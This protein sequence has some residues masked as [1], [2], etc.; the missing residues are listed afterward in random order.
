MA[1]QP[2]RRRKSLRHWSLLRHVAD[3]RANVYRRCDGH[4]L[5]R[6][7]AIELCIDLRHESADYARHFLR[8]LQAG[9]LAH[10]NTADRS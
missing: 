6:Q 4:Y 8:R 9:S 2:S 3:P 1:P 5:H 7:S 10:R